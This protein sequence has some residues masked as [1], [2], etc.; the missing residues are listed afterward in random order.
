MIVQ[1]SKFCGTMTAG[2]LLDRSVKVACEMPQSFRS[3]L[4]RSYSAVCHLT[5][6]SSQ[7]VCRDVNA[8]RT[9]LIHLCVVVC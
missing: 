6:A 9:N 3:L 8:V 7:P 5:A 1:I 4:R 2:V